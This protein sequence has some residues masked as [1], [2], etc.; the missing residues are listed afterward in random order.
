MSSPLLLYNSAF[1]AFLAT[2][3]FIP[4]CNGFAG[5][6]R[7]HLRYVR[8]LSDDHFS[9]SK[10]YSA[11]HSTKQNE[12]DG[13]EE[14]ICAAVLVPGFLTGAAEFQP[15]CQTLTERGL[16]TV[17]VP[18]PN[19]HWIPC[20]GGRSARPILERIDFTV[21]HVIA[22]DGDVTK[23]PKF[24]YSLWDTWIDFCNNPGGIL[25]VGGSSRVDDYPVVQ[26]RGKFPT[27]ENLPNKK[28]ALIGHSAGGWI[29]RVYLSTREYGGKAYCGSNYIHSL[30]TL[31]T[32]HGDAPGPAFE[33]VKWINAEEVPVRALSVAGTG[34][35]GGDWGS[36]TQGSYAFCCPEGSDGTG[37]DG[38]GVTPTFSSLAM[39]GS[40][41]LLV[42]DVSHFCWSDVFGGSLFAPE[43]TE[44][45]KRGRAWY[46][47]D[48]IVD[49]WASFVL[50]HVPQCKLR[51][52]KSTVSYE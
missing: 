49:Q 30:I 34:F 9:G 26:P 42:E 11:L 33:G 31:G 25:Q 2:A 27:S 5:A 38:D 39:P 20:L 50:D 46:G 1:L 6:G 48:E 24:D 45:H 35:K 37:Y 17:A 16:P 13:S 52:E 29:S 8:Q 3:V 22:N 7:Y 47:T 19:W 32:P 43:L 21:K 12:N 51:L 44:D 14:L 4:P 40:E 23:I 28:V 15:L 10:R 41:Q 18:M 36:L